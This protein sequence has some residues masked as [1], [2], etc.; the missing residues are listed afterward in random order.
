M[1][2]PNQKVQ[3][4]TTAEKMALFSLLKEQINSESATDEERAARYKENRA[5]ALQAATSQQITSDPEITKKERAIVYNS[6]K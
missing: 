6:K 4:E 3:S 2:K 1:S 5:K